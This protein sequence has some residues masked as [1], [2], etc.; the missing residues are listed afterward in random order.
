MDH[1]QV[2]CR[3]FLSG[4]SYP[5]TLSKLKIT[6]RIAGN[7]KGFYWEHWLV[8][9]NWLANWGILKVKWEKSQ[10]VRAERFPARW[11]SSLMRPRN[12]PK[13][14]WR[15]SPAEW[16]RLETVDIANSSVLTPKKN[17]KTRTSHIQG[18]LMPFDSN[19]K[20]RI[21]ASIQ[22]TCKKYITV[23]LIMQGLKHQSWWKLWKGHL[24]TIL[25]TAFDFYSSSVCYWTNNWKTRKSFAAG[26]SNVKKIQHKDIFEK[27]IR[28]IAKKK[29]FR[30]YI[31]SIKSKNKFIYW[32]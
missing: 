20:T 18:V 16:G 15:H 26:R 5:M 4:S 21:Y 11:V 24:E 32:K 13:S 30:L 8:Q 29:I 14:S 22:I 10:L 1:I 17:N 7:Q 23:L 2:F 28:I 3:K 6:V 27:K 12:C 31:I 25:C 19:R 9:V